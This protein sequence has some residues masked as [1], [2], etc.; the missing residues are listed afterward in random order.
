MIRVTAGLPL[1]PQKAL[2]PPACCALTGRTRLR[3]AAIRFVLFESELLP[4]RYAAKALRFVAA[5]QEK[6]TRALYPKSE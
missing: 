1:L 2:G 5:E 4:E 6:A 3:L